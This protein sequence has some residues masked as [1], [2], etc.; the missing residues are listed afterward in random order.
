MKCDNLNTQ[1]RADIDINSTEIRSS[2]LH[3]HYRTCLSQNK[4]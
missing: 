1:V 2:A 3:Q 4:C